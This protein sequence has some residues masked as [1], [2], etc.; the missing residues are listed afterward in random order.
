MEGAAIRLPPGSVEA[1]TACHGRQARGS[2]TVGLSLT[3]SVRPERPI[4]GW[5]TLNAF[6]PWPLQRLPATGIGQPST[7][8]FPRLQ[9]G[10]DGG[11]QVGDVFGDH[12]SGKQLGG[13]HCLE[14]TETG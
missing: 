9:F 4:L 12:I 2:S 11:F 1:T 6:L 10:A 3:Q 14:R 13:R 5:W 7:T 8:T